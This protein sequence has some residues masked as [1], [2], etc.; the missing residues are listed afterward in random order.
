MNQIL[1]NEEG[2]DEDQRGKMPCGKRDLD[3][4]EELT[5][6]WAV[7]KDWGWTGILSEDAGDVSRCHRPCKKFSL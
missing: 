5:E 1:E 3:A 4:Y 6:S 7:H 2:V